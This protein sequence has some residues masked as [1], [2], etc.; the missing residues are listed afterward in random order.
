MPRLFGRVIPGMMVKRGTPSLRLRSEMRLLGERNLDVAV[1]AVRSRAGKGAALGGV[2][3][4]VGD[5]LQGVVDDPDQQV[6]DQVLADRK[7]GDRR[8]AQA[9]ELG[10]G[11]D[12]GE[13]QEARRIER[14]GT[15]DDLARADRLHRAIVALDNDTLSAGAVHREPQHRVSR[16]AD[17]DSVDPAPGR[18][19]RGRR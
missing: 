5:R 4:A 14:P 12:P 6:I 11:T 15:D 18:R 16:S 19:T 8:N 1:G 17:A 10:G 3:V 7:I 9:L 13:K 2:G